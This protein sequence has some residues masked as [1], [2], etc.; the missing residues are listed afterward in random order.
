MGSVEVC[1]INDPFDKL[2]RAMLVANDIPK[3]L[4]LPNSLEV[5]A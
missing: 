3:A 5:S 1:E 4:C 2:L